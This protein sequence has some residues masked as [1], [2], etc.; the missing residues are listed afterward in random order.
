VTSVKK[1]VF[2]D[3]LAPEY[4]LAGSKMPEKIEGLTFGPKLKDGRKTLLIASD[5]DFLIDQ[6]TL[7]YVFAFKSTNTN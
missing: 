1:E 7:I 4:G 3:L 6:P 5:N 2:I